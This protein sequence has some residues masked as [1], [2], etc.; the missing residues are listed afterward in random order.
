MSRG[1]SKIEGDRV[2]CFNASMME[3]RIIDLEIRFSHQDEFIHQLNQIVVE[4]QKIIERLEKD[5]LDLKRNIN[6][7]GGVAPTR[8]LSDD[9]PPHY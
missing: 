7:E 3:K 6:S 9:K 1:K 8:T 5:I 4:Q 2:L